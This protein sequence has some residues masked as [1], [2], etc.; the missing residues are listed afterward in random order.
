MKLIPCKKF[1]KGKCKRGAKCKF[2]HDNIRDDDDNDQ[3]AGA[4]VPR[5]GGGGGGGGGMG[6]GGGAVRAEAMMLA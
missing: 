4:P 5:G 3:D 1:Q 2:S 6:G